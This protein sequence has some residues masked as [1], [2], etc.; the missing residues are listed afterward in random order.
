MEEKRSIH[1]LRTA[2]AMAAERRQRSTAGGAA[3]AGGITEIGYI[4]EDG[5]GSGSNGYGSS[6]SGRAAMHAAAAVQNQY[7]KVEG[8]TYRVQ[9]VVQQPSDAATLPV[10]QQQ[11]DRIRRCSDAQTQSNESSFEALTAQQHHLHSRPPLH[12]LTTASSA[13]SAVPAT[14]MTNNC[15][16][17]VEPL[18]PHPPSSSSSSQPRVQ[19]GPVGHVLPHPHSHSHPL[20]QSSAVPHSVSSSRNPSP[21][22][23]PPPHPSSMVPPST[24]VSV[25]APP[26]PVPYGYDPSYCQSLGV[27]ADGYQYEL[28]RRPSLGNPLAT[29]AATE[30]A[31]PSDPV[32][33]RPSTG[34]PYPPAHHYP[35]GGLA[36]TS[37]HGSFDSCAAEAGTRPAPSPSAVAAAAA[38]PPLLAP[39]SHSPSYH[40]HSSQHFLYHAPPAPPTAQPVLFT[41]QPPFQPASYQMYR[42][43]SVSSSG[44]AHPSASS[45]AAPG[46]H[47]HLPPA[48]AGLTPQPPPP[49]VGHMQSA[50]RMVGDHVEATGTSSELSMPKMIHETSI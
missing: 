5:S 42:H 39:S 37:L 48:H 6:K 41:Q 12:P 35:Y 31:V 15:D 22:P 36:A 24:F 18:Q 50:F 13:L 30:L 40:L 44:G 2:A 38:G 45:S 16:A 26:S 21:V 9:R 49:V 47:P 1:S 11:A 20:H 33:R 32:L 8:Q 43:H 14:T 7:L 4:D 25:P 10:P 17:A 19:V 34:S 46:Y 3:N 23:P 28:V 29:P 27:A